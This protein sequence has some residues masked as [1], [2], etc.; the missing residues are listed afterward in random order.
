[1][2]AVERAA[3]EAHVNEQ[4]V[5]FTPRKGKSPD[6][7]TAKNGGQTWMT[8]KEARHLASATDIRPVE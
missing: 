6:A 1:V 8:A 5:A 4:V 3:S 7:I 2:D